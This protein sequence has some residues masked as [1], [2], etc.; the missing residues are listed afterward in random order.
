MSGYQSAPASQAARSEDE[1]S[2]LRPAAPPV[3][4]S[5]QDR[6]HLHAIVTRYLRFGRAPIPVGLPGVHLGTRTGPHVAEPHGTGVSGVGGVSRPPGSVAAG[7]A[8]LVRQVS[9]RESA[10]RLLESTAVG[11]RYA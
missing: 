2:A 3:S 6:R 1:T 5:L 9:V 7:S 4:V 10:V 11:V 8:H